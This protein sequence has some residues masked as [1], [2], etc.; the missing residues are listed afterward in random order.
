MSNYL[1]I[2]TPAKLAQPKRYDPDTLPVDKPREK[3]R[4]FKMTAQKIS[5]R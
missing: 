2:K 1:S 4:G 3:V 5:V